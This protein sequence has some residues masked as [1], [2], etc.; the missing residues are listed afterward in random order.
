LR[1]V[2]R[3]GFPLLSRVA[4]V[5]REPDGLSALIQA[6][7]VARAAA[8]TQGQYDDAGPIL[9]AIPV[10][11]TFGAFPGARERGTTMITLLF[12][13]PWV[14]FARRPLRR[15]RRSGRQH[16]V[17]AAVPEGGTR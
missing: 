5:Q 3:F 9:G 6:E 8:V 2:K 13:P 15:P 1:S 16:A 4:V 11:N 10:P 7:S 14:G 17:R 12:M